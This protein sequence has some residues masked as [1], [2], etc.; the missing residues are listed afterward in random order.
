MKE[1]QKKMEDEYKSRIKKRRI[2]KGNFKKMG[3]KRG[4]KKMR[5][6]RRRRRQEMGQSNRKR[7]GKAIP[8]T[9]REG[10]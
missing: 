5:N 10:P 7:K 9:G 1:K 3:W 2:L 4:E 8:V 6:T